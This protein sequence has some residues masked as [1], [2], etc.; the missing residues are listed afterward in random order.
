MQSCP[1]LGGPMECRF[2]VSSVHGFFR[3]Q[4]WSGLPFPSPWDL[5]DPGTE[6]RC[7]TF[8][9][10]SL[11]SE[12][13]KALLSHW[14]SSILWLHL[15]KIIKIREDVSRDYFRE[16]ILFFSPFKKLYC[17]STAYIV[18]HV[19]VFNDIASFVRVVLLFRGHCFASTKTE[20][21]VI[22]CT[23]VR[24]SHDWEWN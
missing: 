12:P 22:Y 1:T 2:S 20:E 7:P 18:Q 17:G 3:Q 19:Y 16:V 14:G 24:F 21:E 11:P 10:D 9:A 6:L 15:S 4:Y 8:Q 23:R 13:P 5:P